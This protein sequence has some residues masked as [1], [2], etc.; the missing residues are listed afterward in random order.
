MGCSGRQHL[1]NRSLRTFREDRWW[2]RWGHGY[3]GSRCVPH[4]AH[5]GYASDD[6]VLTDEY[7]WQMNTS[8]MLTILIFW[9]WHDCRREYT[10]L[11]LEGIWEPRTSTIIIRCRAFELNFLNKNAVEQH[12]NCFQV[13]WHSVRKHLRHSQATVLQVYYNKHGF[14]TQLIHATITNK[15]ARTAAVTVAIF[16][17]A[18]RANLL[19]GIHFISQ[20][21]CRAAEKLT[22]LKV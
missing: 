1:L 20:L 11:R 5:N 18:A 12:D 22:S 19:Q 16:R 9:M 17:A 13:K 3:D 4:S 15:R 6:A 10:R 2:W 21:W 8:L 14:N 7:C